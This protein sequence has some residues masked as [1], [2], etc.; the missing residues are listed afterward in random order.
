MQ[1]LGIVRRFTEFW[2]TKKPECFSESVVSSVSLEGSFALF[3]LL[4]AGIVISFG[5]FTVEMGLFRK[6]WQRKGSEK[7][8][9][10]RETQ[11]TEA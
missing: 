9:I 4:I 7:L 8:G 11:S 6:L 1:E 2:I 3:L 10:Y 5:A